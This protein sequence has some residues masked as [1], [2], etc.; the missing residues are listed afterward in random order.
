MPDYKK[1]V[2]YKEKVYCKTTDGHV[3]II[4]VTDVKLNECPEC[5]LV[6]LLKDGDGTVVL[7]FVNQQ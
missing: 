2:R 4:D 3:V 6:E 7:D 1:C 5:V